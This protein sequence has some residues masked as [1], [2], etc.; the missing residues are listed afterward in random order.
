MSDITT[1]SNEQVKTDGVQQFNVI[2]KLIIQCVYIY[3]TIDMRER[4]RRGR[5][6]RESFKKGGRKRKQIT[7]IACR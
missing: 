5:G 3:M 7:Y 6:K 2:T 4:E 1:S